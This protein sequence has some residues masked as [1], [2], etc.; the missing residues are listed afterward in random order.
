M[1]VYLKAERGETQAPSL[2]RQ[3]SGSS[4][5]GSFQQYFQGLKDPRVKRRRLHPLIDIVTIAILAVSQF[6]ILDFRL[7][8]DFTKTNLWD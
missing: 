7:G 8:R 1:P 5:I 4:I 3:D 6:W 2:L